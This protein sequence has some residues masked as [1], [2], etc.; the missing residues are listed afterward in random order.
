[1]N[2][3]LVVGIDLGVAVAAGL[4]DVGLIRRAFWIG[5]A[6]NVVRAVAALAVGRHQQPFLAERESVNGIDVV[7]VDTRQAVLARH[8][9][10]AVAGPQVLGTLSG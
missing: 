8:A 1:M 4:G 6:E 7:R 2:A 9:V 3:L 5:M 10:I